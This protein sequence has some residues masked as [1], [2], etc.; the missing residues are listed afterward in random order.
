MK[1]L[2]GKTIVVTGATGA[3]GRSLCQMLARHGC[4]LGLVSRTATQLQTLSDQL[5]P[6]A[7]EVSFQCVD[8]RRRAAVHDAMASLQRELGPIDVLI[9][10]AGVGRMTCAWAPDLDEVEEMLQVNYLAGVY[11]VEAVLPGMLQRGSG[12]LVAVSSLA[13][14]R[15]M[16]F[17]AGYSASKAAFATYLESLRPALR[18]RGIDVSTCYLG[19]VRTPMSRALPLHPMLWMLSPEAA[20]KRILRAVARRRSEAYFPWYDACG[21]RFLRRLPSRLLDLV[22]VSLGRLTLSGDY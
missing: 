8:L 12:Q 17:T 9:H 19:F 3:I 1:E 18:R 20:G 6:V 10:N 21:A 15:G 16:A 2:D 11:A 7:T 22:M 14:L 5:R 4:R 13:A